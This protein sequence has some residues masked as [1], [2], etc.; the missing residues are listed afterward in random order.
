MG[1]VGCCDKSINLYQT[2]RCHSYLYNTLDSPYFSCQQDVVILHFFA[3]LHDPTLPFHPLLHFPRSACLCHSVEPRLLHFT[4]E[5]TQCL[6][7]ARHFVPS[8]I[9]VCS[10]PSLLICFAAPL[11]SSLQTQHICAVAVLSARPA[12]RCHRHTWSVRTQQLV[13]S[14]MVDKFPVF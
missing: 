2:T 9:F 4:Q 6:Q 8:T 3:V 1:P 12:L 10:V 14:V 7:S 13:A 5:F 11:P